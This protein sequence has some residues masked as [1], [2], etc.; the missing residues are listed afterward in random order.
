MSKRFVD[1]SKYRQHWRK[2]DPKLRAA[3]Y[4]LTENSDA[5]GYWVI[6][7]DHFKFECGYGLDIERLIQETGAVEKHGAKVL[8]LIDFIETNYGA[9]REGYNPHKP[10]LRALSHH[11]ISSLNQASMKLEDEEE[12]KEEDTTK[13][14]ERA[15]AKPPDGFDPFWAAYPIHK[16]KADAVK[17]WGRLSDA[18]RNLCL[19]AITAQVKAHHFRGKDGQDFI[20]YGASWL[21]ARR[22]EDEISSA[23]AKQEPMAWKEAEDEMNA[24]RAKSGRRIVEPHEMSERLRKYNGF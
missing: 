9:L 5:A 7:L 14:K 11:Q 6:D 8:R 15:T 18:E 20:P 2:L 24:I 23:A 10:A 3:F 19:P 12:D 16:A 13:K 22:W 17:A 1:T 4:W 21:N